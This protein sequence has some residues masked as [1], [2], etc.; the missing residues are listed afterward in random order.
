MLAV[1]APGHPLAA[2]ERIEPADLAAEHLIVYKT[3][4]RDSY[5]FTRILDPAG[6]EPV[7]VSKV[8][9]TEAI[10]EMVKAGMGVAVMARWVIAPALDS[11]AVRAL[12]IIRRRSAA[13]LRD[14]REPRW[15]ADFVEL[16][17]DRALPA[18]AK[19]FRL[20]PGAS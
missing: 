17:R 12:G 16:L 14:R 20:R 4:R 13:T 3:E 8:P 19:V 1:V 10:L 2:R 5:V 9:L 18:R 6:V 15:Q 7:R 11:G